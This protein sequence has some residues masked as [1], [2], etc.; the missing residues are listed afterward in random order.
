VN[1]ADSGKRIDGLEFVFVELPKFRPQTLPEKRLQVLWLRYLTEIG[2]TSR[3][4]PDE[5]LAQAEVNEAI[6]YLRE[7]AFSEEEMAA[8]DKYWD[9]IRV[10]RTLL[11][12]A[13]A[14]GEAKGR[15]EGR[16][17]GEEKTRK[18]IARSMLADGFTGGQVAKLAG[19]KPAALENL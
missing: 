1:M 9:G 7:S 5:M 16:A 12:D 2:E 6:E 4:V 18:A 14:E 15:T 11:S 8:Y 10:E 13:L 17:E 3:E 19:M